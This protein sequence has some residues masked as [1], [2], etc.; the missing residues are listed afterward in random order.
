ML[1]AYLF[2]CFAAVSYMK[3]A[4]L[5]AQGVDFARS[6]SPPSRRRSATNSCC[7]DAQ[8]RF[9]NYPLVVPTLF[10]TFAFLIVVAILMFFE[11][12][13]VGLFHGRPISV[14]VA[15]TGGT[16]E[17][18]IATGVLLLLIFVPYFALRSLSEVVGWNAPS[19]NSSLFVIV[20][21]ISI[22][23]V[24][25]FESVTPL[26]ARVLRSEYR[27][28][29]SQRFARRRPMSDEIRDGM[30]RDP[31]QNEP[32]VDRRNAFRRAVGAAAATA[33]AAVGLDL[34]SHRPSFSKGHS[35]PSAKG[36]APVGFAEPP[37]LCISS[38]EPQNRTKPMVASPYG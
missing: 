37:A 20:K 24:L 12:A 10:R 22:R 30:E 2:V 5:K 13:I 25:L 36:A 33:A 3:F 35:T 17:E 29:G 19:T 26:H 28:P 34:T 15:E 32:S 7:L 8:R 14:S 1:T 27:A 4:V 11:E 21:A 23:E 6:P 38:A 18:R 9:T 16:L 31:A